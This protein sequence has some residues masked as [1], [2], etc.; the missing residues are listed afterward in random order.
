MVFRLAAAQADS[1]FVPDVV[2]EC[3]GTLAETTMMAS[4]PGTAAV[5]S[6]VPRL[7]ASSWSPI[8]TAASPRVKA[9][10]Q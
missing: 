3:I 1:K 10:A 8:T 6:A 5:A 9:T 2:A 4:L 7:A